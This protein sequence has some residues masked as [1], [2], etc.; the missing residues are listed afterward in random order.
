[1]I[2]DEAGVLWLSNPW[3]ALAMLVG[4]VALVMWCHRWL[5]TGSAPMPRSMA[6]RD[7][8]RVMRSRA[9]RQKS[10]APVIHL[11]QVG[12][13]PLRAVRRTGVPRT[14]A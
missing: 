10:A 3:I 6:V 11:S 2:V 12:R 5:E 8:S 13:A 7:R 4:V 9:L 1:M 14:A